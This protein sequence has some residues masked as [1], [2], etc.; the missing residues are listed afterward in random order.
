M[1]LNT[2]TAPELIGKVG[3]VT[4]ASRGIGAAI[5][6][7]LAENGVKLLLVSRTTP[8]DKLI[9]ALEKLEAEYLH[10]PADLSKVEMVGPIMAAALAR[11]NKVDILVNNAGTIRRGTVLEHTE[12]DW[13][14]VLNTNLKVP[15]FLA[16]A[17]AKQILAQGGRGKIINICS[18]LSFQGGILVPGYSAAKHGL[19]GVTKAMANELAPK[20]IN[21]NGIAPGYI[22]TENTRALQEDME[23][24][25][26][27]VSRIPE[28]RWGEAE[29]I[30]GAAVFLASN[31]SDYINGHILA[32]DGGWL[33]R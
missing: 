18:L 5:A 17:V 6:L 2:V 7:K 33:A 13:D 4:G 31:A 15:F 16:Q 25:K 14:F 22:R 28:G 27:I 19:S 29:E 11:F 24:D 26:A 30:A 32:V 10:F 23:R 21:I 8:E 1:L 3:I 20:G 12:E 9:T